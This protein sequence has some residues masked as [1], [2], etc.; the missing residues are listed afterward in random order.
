MENNTS[1]LNSF[2]PSIV[3]SVSVLLSSFVIPES[4]QAIPEDAP[5]PRLIILADMGNEPDEEQQM[6]HMLMYSNEFDIEGLI[7]VTGKYLKTGPRPTRME[8]R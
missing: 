1:K 4:V 7:A 2:A 8:T 6:V 5:P 3:L